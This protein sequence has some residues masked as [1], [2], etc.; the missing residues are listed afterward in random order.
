MEVVEYEK[1]WFLSKPKQFGDKRVDD[2][3][4]RT[5]DG[6]HA[7]KQGGSSRCETRRYLATRSN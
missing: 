4:A 5:L 3:L 7:A 6:S 1:R 2:D